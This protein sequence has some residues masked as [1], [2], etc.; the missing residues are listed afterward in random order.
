MMDSASSLQ[1][2]PD[3]YEAAKVAA[4]DRFKRAYDQWLAAKAFTE[5]TLR[6]YQAAHQG[7]IVLKV[8]AARTPPHCGYGEGETRTH[9][10][11]DGPC[12]ECPRCRAARIDGG[13][14][15]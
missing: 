7:L 11:H 3:P 6:E 2:M 13:E 10:F 5:E 9:A 4:E 15:A 14:G 8:K 1:P 12:C